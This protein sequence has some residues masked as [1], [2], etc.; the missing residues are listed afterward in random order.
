MGIAVPPPLP[1][2]SIIPSQVEWT[3]YFGTEYAL[4]VFWEMPDPGT[5]SLE[6]SPGPG[7]PWV[8]AGTL[9][10]THPGSSRYSIDNVEYTDPQVAYR[11]TKT[12]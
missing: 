7:K 6:S 8:P 2:G 10:H 9:G 1:I 11:M 12:G 5:Y 3:G 4:N